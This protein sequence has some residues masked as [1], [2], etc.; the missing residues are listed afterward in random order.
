MVGN[1]IKVVDLNNGKTSVTNDAENV[2]KFLNKH[3][4]LEHNPEIRII[5][6]DTEG[7]WDEIKHVK[8][9][10]NGFRYVGTKTFEDAVKKIS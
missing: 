5:Y 9:I 8:G 4:A 2:V 7:T 1:I 6:R 3:Y 10:F